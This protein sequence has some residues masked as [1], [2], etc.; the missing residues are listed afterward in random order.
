M[1]IFYNLNQTLSYGCPVNLVLSSRGIG[2]TYAVKERSVRNFLKEGEQFVYIRRYEAELNAVKNLLF[3]DTMQNHVCPGTIQSVGGEF[4][5]SDENLKI[6]KEVMGY[7]VA[8]SKAAQ[9]KSASYPNVTTIIFDEFLIDTAGFQRY[10]KKEIMIFLDI[11]E[12]VIRMRDNVKVFLLANTLSMYNPYVLHWDISLP[13]GKNVW[14]SENGLVL[15]QIVTKKNFNEE[16][17]KSMMGKLMSGTAYEDYAIH[18]QFLLDSDIFLEK[19]T[20]ECQ[21]LFMIRTPEMDVGLWR[22]METKII[23]GSEDIDPSNRM[24]YTFDKDT[25]DE[26]VSLSTG[27]EGQIKALLKCYQRSRMRFETAKVKAS[28]SRL[29]S[30]WV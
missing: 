9:F 6:N 15:F 25:H 24:I 18:N 22:N 26:K 4:L 5:Y 17:Q 23:Y 16:K 1:S 13:K 11:L 19:K 28:L 7:S 29:F 30:K 14:K 3:S 20:G 27:K 8:L 10:L 2:K 21:Y 12:T